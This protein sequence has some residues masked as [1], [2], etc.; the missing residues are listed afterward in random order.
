[1]DD[2]ISR[3]ATLERMKSMAGC[4][5]CDNYNY[6]RCRACSWDDAM[7]IVEE[8]SKVDAVQVV[9]ASWI[10]YKDD[11]QCSA[12][13]EHTIFDAYVWK[14]IQFEFCPWCGANMDG[15]T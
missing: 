12:C 8:M 7:N 11:H 14:T 5:T 13:K 6:V 10:S 2:L 1:M 15:E 3:A 4:A 9:H